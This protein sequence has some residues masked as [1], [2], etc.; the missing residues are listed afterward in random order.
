MSLPQPQ[1][2]ATRSP[3][4]IVLIVIGAIAAAL[5]LLYGG[6]SL[7][8]WILPGDSPEAAAQ[9]SPMTGAVALQVAD[10]PVYWQE[11]TASVDWRALAEAPAWDGTW[12]SVKTSMVADSDA[13]QPAMAMCATLSGYWISSG[14]EFHSV[15]VLAKTGSVL[16]SRRTQGEQ[17]TWR[18]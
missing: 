18:R 15:R 10:L 13:R 12:L 7:L 3:R 1:P 9:Q 17:C 2:A 14:Q 11:Q 5:L 6:A 8:T 16:V 4:S